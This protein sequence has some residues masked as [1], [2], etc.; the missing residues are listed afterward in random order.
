MSY[1]SKIIIYVDDIVSYV[2]D[3]SVF[4]TDQCLDEDLHNISD[5]YRKN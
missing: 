3:K 1:N 4:K 2:R 5:D